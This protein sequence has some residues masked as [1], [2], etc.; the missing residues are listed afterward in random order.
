MT[1][2]KLSGDIKIREILEI[3]PQRG[4]CL[5]VTA[6][7]AE[8]QK[9]SALEEVLENAQSNQNSLYDFNVC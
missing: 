2:T 6:G 8:A 4:F 9:G 7:I 3:N 1:C 5:S